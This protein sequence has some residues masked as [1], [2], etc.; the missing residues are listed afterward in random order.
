MYR[1]WRLNKL[2]E[3]YDLP[4]ASEVADGAVAKKTPDNEFFCEAPS[5]AN[6]AGDN[7]GGMAISMRPKHAVNIMK[8]EFPLK[9]VDEI[10]VYMDTEFIP[11]AKLNPPCYLTV[12]HEDD[13]VGEQLSTVFLRLA[14]EYVSHTLGEDKVFTVDI[15]RLYITRVF[16]ETFDEW[17]QPT[18]KPWY[19][20]LTCLF[21]LKVPP[22]IESNDDSN[23]GWSHLRWGSDIEYDDNVLRPSNEEFVKPE[24][25]TLIMF[26]SWLQYNVVPFSGESECRILAATISLSM[27]A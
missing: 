7:A 10:N 22:Q 20:G 12:S 6:P 5:Q 15:E 3:I 2:V 24:V 11:N 1:T 18:S 27:A 4:A 19:S 26:P 21:Y 14:K 8:V 13:E 17:Q 16:S 23:E 9:I 25:G